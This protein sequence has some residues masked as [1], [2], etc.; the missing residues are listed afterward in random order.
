MNRIALVEDHQRLSALL[1]KALLNAGIETDIF[2]RMDPA[3][4][5]RSLATHLL[6]T[7]DLQGDCRGT[8]VG[9]RRTEHRT[10]RGVHTLVAREH[11]D[12]FYRR[13][14]RLRTC[15]DL[16][17]AALEASDGFDVLSEWQEIECGERTEA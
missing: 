5:V 4:L 1:G 10:W 17:S 16:A 14:I 8:Q 6:G 11:G 7:F 9:S 2:G 12:D 13:G 3:A 15:H